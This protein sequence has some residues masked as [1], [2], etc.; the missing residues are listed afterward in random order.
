MRLTASINGFVAKYMSG[1][2]RMDMAKLRETE[3][4]PMSD[5][6]FTAGISVSRESDKISAG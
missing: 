3:R 2:A 5:S 1:L 4:R 6:K